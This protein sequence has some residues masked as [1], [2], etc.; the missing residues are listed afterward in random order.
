MFDLDRFLADC[1]GALTETTPMLA[2][3]DLVARTVQDSFDLDQTFGPFRKGGTQVLHQGPDLT[4]MHIVWPPG[5]NIFPHDHQMWA[6]IGVHAGVEENTFYRRSADGLDQAGFKRLEDKDS[7]ALAA[8]TI[9]SVTNPESTPTAAIHIY[10]GDF[11]KV[12]RS[13]FDAET[14]AEKPFDM[15]HSNRL[16]EEANTRWQRA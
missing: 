16:F 2:V 8:D 14:H 7:R 10:G 6:V 3:K 12:S 9:H 4:V 11:L 1:H 13:Q 5:I 15:N